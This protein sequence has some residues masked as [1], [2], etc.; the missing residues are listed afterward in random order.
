MYNNGIVKAGEIF[1]LGV[2]SGILDYQGC[3]CSF[4]GKQLGAGREEVIHFLSRDA[5]LS[6][7]IEQAIRQKML[8]TASS[9]PTED[10]G[11]CEDDCV[12][13]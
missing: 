4:R 13:S 6:T 5:H 7:T 2:H 3:V 10:A 9:T 11:T 12:E 8:P 1:D